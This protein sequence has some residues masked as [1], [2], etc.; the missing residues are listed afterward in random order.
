MK[1]YIAVNRNGQS[2]QYHNGSDSDYDDIVSSLY[3]CFSDFETP[4]IALPW[5]GIMSGINRAG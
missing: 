5:V 4:A 1:D 2:T 3:F